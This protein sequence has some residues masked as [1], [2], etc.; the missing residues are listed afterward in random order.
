MWRF[1]QLMYFDICLIYELS[2]NIVMLIVYIVFDYYITMLN[3]C[4]SHC[5]RIPRL[6]GLCDSG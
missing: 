3:Y 5:K 2:F 1:L 6:Y 4:V